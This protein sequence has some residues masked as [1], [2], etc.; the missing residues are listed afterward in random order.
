VPFFR[1]LTNPAF[2]SIFRW[3][4]TTG[5]GSLRWGVISH[6]HFSRS[7]RKAIMS[8][9]IGSE[10]ALKILALNRVRLYGFDGIIENNSYKYLNIVMNIATI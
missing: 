6:T 7:R 8:S 5:W 10:R 9:L 4:E 1:R 2:F 3:R